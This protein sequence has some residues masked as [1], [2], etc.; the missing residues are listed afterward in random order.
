MKRLFAGFLL[1]AYLMN[2]EA[3][4]CAA[5]KSKAESP[6][7][8]KTEKKRQVPFR[9]KVSTVDKVAKTIALEG[10]EKQR[11][12]QITSETKIT[13]DGKPAVFDNVAAGESVGGLAR[14]NAAGKLEVVTL[15]VGAKSAKAK[16][17][18]EKE[19]K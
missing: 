8:A 2:F 7:A 6:E 5:E 17:D 11:V 4:V 13:R 18:E 16:S 15:N 14:E 12:F 19:K 3:P 1:G 10:K 9:G